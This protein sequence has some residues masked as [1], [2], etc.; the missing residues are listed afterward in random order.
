MNAAMP[1]A[2][3]PVVL[4]V[5]CSGKH[6]FSKPLKEAIRLIENWGVEGDAHAGPNDQHL[7]HIRR[8]GQQPNLRQVHLIHSEL[9]DDVRAKGHEVRPGELGEN[10]STR[11]LDLL[12]LPQGTRLHIG[13]QAVIELTGLRN[14]CRQI[15]EFQP[16]LRSHLVER[17]DAGVVRRGGVM[18][19][20][21]S[22]GIVR[23][24]DRIEVELPRPP[25]APLVYRMPE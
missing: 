18:S 5:H 12:G 11:N 15:D 4:A 13:P 23:P 1:V 14:P 17:T 3:L 6:A 2:R 24:E 25:H 7:Y 8:F 10:I 16:G 21:L 9:L 19:I 20:V 22:G